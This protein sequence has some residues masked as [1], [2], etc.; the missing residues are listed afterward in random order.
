MASATPRV[1]ACIFDMDGLLLDTET[2]YT[3]VTNKLIEPYNKTFALETKVKMMG[4]DVRTATDILLADLEIPLTFDEYNDQA[5]AL[6]KVFFRRAELM[7]GVARL[8]RHLA[9]NSIPIA[10]ATSSGKDMFLVKT[11]RHRELFGLFGTN[12]TCGDDPAVKHPKPAPDIFLTA[13]DRLDCGLEPSDC[14]VFEDASN[15]VEA[16][17]RAN[18]NCVWVHDAR[19]MLDPLAP[20]TK[21]D[22]TERIATLES[23]DPAKYGLPPFSN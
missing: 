3:E 6:K 1:K 20:P 22:A 5:N 21:H 17:K 2:I 4:R 19:F 18:M 14:L 12:I 13:M 11:E 7:P 10:V 8:I 23:F 15:G 9:K 16:A